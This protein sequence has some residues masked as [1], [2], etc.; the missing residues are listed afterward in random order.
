[1]ADAKNRKNGLFPQ[2]MND[3]FYLV[4]IPWPMGVIAF[5]SGLVFLVLYLIF[6][7]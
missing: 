7:R 4:D 5:G 1:M 6:R 3:S 2:E